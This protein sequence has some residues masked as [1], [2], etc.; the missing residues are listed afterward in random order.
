[1]ARSL[2]LTS[3]DTI[4]ITSGAGTSIDDIANGVPRA[5]TQYNQST[6]SVAD[7][8]NVDSISDD[9]AGTYTVTFTTDFA[10]ANYV[11]AGM[12]AANV[13]VRRGASQAAGSMEIQTR[14][15]TTD[16]LTDTTSYVI[17]QGDQ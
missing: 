4:G 13:L 2:D 17:Y 11:M 8:Y 15:N 9:S 14:G 6:P 16:T 5:R 10:S 12:A 1:M 7:S 3:G